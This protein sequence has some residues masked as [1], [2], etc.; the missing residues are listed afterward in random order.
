M[1]KR[2]KG[3]SLTQNG[4]IG[5]GSSLLERRPETKEKPLKKRSDKMGDELRS[6]YDLGQLLKGGVRGKYAKHYHAG[7]HLVLLDPDA[8]APT[9]ARPSAV[10][11]QSTT[12]YAW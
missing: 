5:F 6:E 7:T 1:A 10:R 2:S 4:A 11:K 3:W 8:D 12:P 9:S